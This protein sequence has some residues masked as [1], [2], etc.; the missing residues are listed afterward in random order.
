MTLSPSSLVVDFSLVGS[1][2][3]KSSS[4]IVFSK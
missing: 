3:D 4:H 1:K 2:G